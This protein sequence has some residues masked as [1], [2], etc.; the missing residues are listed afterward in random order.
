MAEVIKIVLTGGP[1]GGKTTALEFLKENLKK[2]NIPVFTVQERATKLIMQG[3]TPENMGRYEFHKELFELEYKEETKVSQDAGKLVNEKAVIIFDRGLLDSRAF[4]TQDEFARYSGLF[5]LNE[6]V[7]RNSYDGV[8][9][10]VSAA[11]GAEKYYNLSS[12]TARKESVACA[13]ELDKATMAL[14]TGTPHLK[15]IDNST[16]FKEKLQRLLDEVLAFIGLPEP[17]EIERKFLVEYPNLDMLEK[18]DLCRV[19]KIEQYYIQ[20]ETE[21]NFRIRKRTSGKSILYI[22]TVK[23]KIN[24]LKRTEIETMLTREEYEKY[25]SDKKHIV[26][27]VS[28]YRYCIVSDFQYFELDIYPFWCDKATLEI[29]LLSENSPFKLPD[30]INV[31]RDVTH[32]SNY[33]NFYLA[34][35]YNV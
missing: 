34:Q 12:N 1:C 32:E 31:V 26:G 11:D 14:W 20:N 24:D 2:Y 27:K 13:K 33:R 9:H 7:I 30:F 15:I 35:K 17:L 3:K 16:G 23:I 5:G 6:D 29:E 22:K 21:G 28:K 4:V 18:M 25:I 8:F 10:L 19:V